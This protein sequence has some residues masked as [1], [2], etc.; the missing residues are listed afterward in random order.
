MNKTPMI[1]D[2]KKGQKKINYIYLNY[3]YII[4]K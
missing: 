3:E 2:A 4:Q 1:K